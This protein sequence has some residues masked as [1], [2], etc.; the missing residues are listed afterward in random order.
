MRGSASWKL[1]QLSFVS[2]AVLQMTFA[3]EFERARN[4][5]DEGVALDDVSMKGGSCTAAGQQLAP[6]LPCSC[7]T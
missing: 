4:V 6:L 2:R 5:S 3:A 1:A 7:S